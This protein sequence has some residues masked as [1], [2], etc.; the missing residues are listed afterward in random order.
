[1]AVVK[2]CDESATPVIN[3]LIALGCFLLPLGVF[4]RELSIVH[5]GN[6]ITTIY[7]GL[8]SGTLAVSAF[9]FIGYALSNG[10]L[11]GR[12]QQDFIGERFFFFLTREPCAFPDILVEL[13]RVLFVI[14]IVT[15]GGTERIHTYAVSILSVATAGF[16]Y[17]VPRYWTAGDNSWLLKG[18]RLLQV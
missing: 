13:S 4:R 6:A 1:M 3:G 7:N 2:D 15:G 5:R 12:R 18:S 11:P 14:F 8:L 17:P 10:F 9:F 16:I